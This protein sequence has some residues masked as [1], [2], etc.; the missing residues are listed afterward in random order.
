MIWRFRLI[1]QLKVSIE[2]RLRFKV[3]PYTNV[4]VI[5]LVLKL[6]SMVSE[7]HKFFWGDW[8]EPKLPDDSG[9]VF[10]PNGLVGSLISGREIM[11]L[12]E[13]N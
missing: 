2:S 1:H 8:D 11:S 7:T 6:V 3:H 4:I 5:E 12:L 9:E 10:K 13:E